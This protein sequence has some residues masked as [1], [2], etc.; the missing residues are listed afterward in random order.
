MELIVT[1][2]KMITLAPNPIP[3]KESRWGKMKQKIHDILWDLKTLYE[4]NKIVQYMTYAFGVAVVI[5]LLYS[6]L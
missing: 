6:V 3:R 4:K 2:R 1:Y 5:L